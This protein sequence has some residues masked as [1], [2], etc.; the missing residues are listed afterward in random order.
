MW[1]PR[2]ASGNFEFNNRCM[3]TD[4]KFTQ[5]YGW[6]EM[7]AK[8]PNG[9]GLWPSFWLYAHNDSTRPE[10]DIME[11]FSGEPSW[12]DSA[13]RPIDFGAT[14]WVSPEDGSAGDQ[15][16]HQRLS[17]IMTGLDLSAGFHKYSLL[18]EPD[19]LTFFFDGK[20]LG[21]KMW[22]TRLNQQMY[23]VVGHGTG[24]PGQFNGASSRTPASIDAAYQINYVRAWALPSGTTTGGSNR[25]PTN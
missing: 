19:G 6:F 11:A 24:K 25:T 23:I 3:N 10:I 15:I 8:L 16:G 5:R 7:E 14:V 13:G 22:T 2:D 12:G 18:W 17:S 9:P 1:T 20:Q 21:G 4:G